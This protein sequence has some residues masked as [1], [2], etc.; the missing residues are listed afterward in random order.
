MRN[1]LHELFH[2]TP[3]WLCKVNTTVISFHRRGNGG[4]KRFSRLTPGHPANKWQ[5]GNTNTGWAGEP[6]VSPVE[7]G[8]VPVPLSP[9]PHL[10]GAPQPSGWG[11]H[12]AAL[13]Q[14]QEELKWKMTQPRATSPWAQ[15][16]RS[17]WGRVIWERFHGGQGQRQSR[18]WAQTSTRHGPSHGG[19]DAAPQP[20]GGAA[21]GLGVTQLRA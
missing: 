21:Q 20:M 3:S 11:G 4:P 19:P 9:T 13:Q 2:P 6:G 7:G 1:P 16:G 10:P 15:R 18:I 17:L 12:R 14:S 5:T 8:G